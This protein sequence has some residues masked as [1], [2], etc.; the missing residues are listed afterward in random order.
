MTASPPPLEG[1]SPLPGLHRRCGELSDRRH[2]CPGHQLAVPSATGLPHRRQFGVYAFDHQQA[3]CREY[4]HPLPLQQGTRGNQLQRMPRQHACRMA[5]CRCSGKR[6]CRGNPASGVSGRGD[7]MH[8]LPCRRTLPATTNGPHGLHNIND[9]RWYNG[10]HEDFYETNPAGC[11]A[12]HG[13]DLTGTPLAKT[14][15]ARAF[16]VEGRAVNLTKGNM[17]SCNRCHSMP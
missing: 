6:Q 14:T 8:G 17:V 5:Q 9:S 10:G 1:P 2:P 15:A 11:R 3:I 13:R 12:C 4:Q 7:G 16:T